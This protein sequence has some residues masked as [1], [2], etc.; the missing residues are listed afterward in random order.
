MHAVPRKIECLSASVQLSVLN[1]VDTTC[2]CHR[3]N[4]ILLSIT[5]VI[6]LND[7]VAIYQPNFAS[8]INNFSRNFNDIGMVSE[9]ES[10]SDSQS[11]VV[12]TTRNH[13]HF[14][15]LGVMVG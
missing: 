9:S 5:R 12:Q 7:N 11:S 2:C 15:S 4:A 8:H 10:R 6:T 14:F 1:T 13:R 3:V